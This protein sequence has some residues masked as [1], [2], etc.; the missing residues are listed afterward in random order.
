[1]WRNKHVFRLHLI[2][3]ETEAFCSK[4]TTWKRVNLE[5]LEKPTDSKPEPNNSNKR[6]QLLSPLY[7]IWRA[8]PNLKTNLN[9]EKAVFFNWLYAML[10]SEFKK[11][12]YNANFPLNPSWWGKCIMKKGC[13]TFLFIQ[14]DLAS[15]CFISTVLQVWRKPAG[16]CAISNQKDKSH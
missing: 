15:F 9:G 7:W 3:A 13:W 6:D 11:D 2:L 16:L 5:I 8:F 1:M 4:K 14:T 12:I 10:S